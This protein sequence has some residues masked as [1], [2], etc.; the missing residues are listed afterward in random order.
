MFL[1]NAAKLHFL[2]HARIHKNKAFSF[3]LS[4]P[5]SSSFTTF[6]AKIQ[7]K[8]EIAEDLSR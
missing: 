4:T 6:G 3:I 8:T 5:H 7:R 2:F 1:K